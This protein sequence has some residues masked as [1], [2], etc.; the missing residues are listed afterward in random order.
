[1]A[2]LHGT[3]RAQQLLDGTELIGRGRHEDSDRV[4]AEARDRTARPRFP[5]STEKSAT[6]ATVLRAPIRMVSS[7][8]MT[9]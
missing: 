2:D 6:A 9:T 4:V 8:P 3:G 5:I 1:M 7:K